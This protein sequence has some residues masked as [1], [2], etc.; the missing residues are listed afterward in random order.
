MNSI[1]YPSHYS[2]QPSR[3]SQAALIYLPRGLLLH[4]P[5]HD[6]LNLSTLRS[7]LSCPVIS[8]NYRCNNEHKHP[9]AIHDVIAGY[10]WVVQ[11]ICNSSTS[12]NKLTREYTGHRIAVCGELLGGSLATTLAL[13]ECRANEPT[14]V[15]AAAVN[16][17]ITSWVDIEED[18]AASIGTEHRDQLT[19]HELH[20]QRNFL[21]RNPAAYFDPFASPALFFRAAGSKVPISKPPLTD[22]EEL[23]ELEKQDFFRTQLALSAVSN[24]YASDENLPSSAVSGAEHETVRKSSRRF[25]SKSLAL[26]LPRFHVT[27]GKASVLAKQSEE[28]A[29]SLSKAVERQSKTR[30]ASSRGRLGADILQRPAASEM[31]MFREFEGEGLWDD[32]E[33]GRSRMRD[34]ALWLE[35]ALR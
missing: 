17:P 9:T 27:S 12:T 7:T 35:E 21:F 20:R 34:T 26:R 15:V 14:A 18:D 24:A 2:P 4:N 29:D 19:V 3:A 32:S 22:M 8:V 11:N 33:G 31:V 13:T 5:K 28:L 30:S 1:Y 10:D 16:N 23:A 6:D 25:P